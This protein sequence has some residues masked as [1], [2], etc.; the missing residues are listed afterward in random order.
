[1]MKRM[2]GR[3]KV[4]MAAGLVTCCVLLFALF[5]IIKSPAPDE[6]V[7]YSED[8]GRSGGADSKKPAIPDRPEEEGFE[9]AWAGIKRQLRDLGADPDGVDLENLPQPDRE[10]WVRKVRKVF[11]MAQKMADE[12]LMR[13]DLEGAR[14]IYRRLQKSAFPEMREWAREA[15]VEIDAFEK[16]LAA[17]VAPK[18]REGLIPYYEK[19][20]RVLRDRDYGAALKKIKRLREEEDA[21]D[22]GGQLS[23]DEQNLLLLQEMLEHAKAGIRQGIGTRVEIGLRTGETVKGKLEG[24]QGGTLS[25]ETSRG[26]RAYPVGFLSADTLV[27]FA[28]SVK[29]SPNSPWRLCSITTGS[30]SRLWRS[31]NGWRWSIRTTPGY[32]QRPTNSSRTSRSCG[33]RWPGK[34]SGR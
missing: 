30:S 32:S 27:R 20:G 16:R 1:M 24:F 7:N 25:V 29:T 9:K 33:S 28:R 3:E 2:S 21:K 5:A 12:K 18:R 8:P 19:F 17:E 13:D 31:S 22:L 15:L 14:E 34:R 10:A 26:R 11:L 4:S 23:W 6:A